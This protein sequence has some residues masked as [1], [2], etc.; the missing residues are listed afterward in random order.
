M[1]TVEIIF[2]PTGGTQKVA[3]M[4]TGRW[5]MDTVTIDLC[6]A[7]ADFSQ[8]VIDK[9]DRVLIAMPSFGGRAPA[10]AIRRLQQ[11]HGNGAKCTLVCV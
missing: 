6:D 8:C 4:M 2:S 10:E 7:K 11:I 3:R 5:N 1:K 9:D